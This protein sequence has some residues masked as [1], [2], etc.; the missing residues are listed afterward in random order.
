MACY[1][2][3]RGL[4][5]ESVR[6]LLGTVVFGNEAANDQTTLRLEVLGAV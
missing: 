2:F 3:V 4:L 1:G 5:S 6:G